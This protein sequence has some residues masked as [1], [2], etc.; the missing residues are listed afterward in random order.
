M[1]DDMF[2]LAEHGTTLRTEVIAGATTFLTMAYITVVNPSVMADAGIAPGA[3][4]IATCLGAGIGTALMAVL[5]NYPIALAPGMGINAYFA[6]GVVVGMGYPWQTALGA[7]FILGMIFLA[8]SVTRFRESVVNAIPRAL[9]LATAAG[10]GLFLAFIGLK[11]AGVVVSDPATFVTGGD[12]TEPTVLLA[13]GCFFA[14]VALEV[15]KVPGALLVAILGTTLVAVMLGYQPWTGVVSTPPSVAPTFL[16]LD[17]GAALDV[18]LITVIFAFFIVDLFDSAGTLIGTAHVGG[19]LDRYGKLPKLREAL[20]ADSAATVAGSCLGTSPVTAYIESVPG[21]RAGGRTGLTAL[22]VA[23]LFLFAVFFAPL[24]A[25]VPSYA[26]APALIYVGCVMAK[27]LTDI[28]WDDLTEYTPALIT[29][30]SMPLTFSI[31]HGLG[32]G[33]VSYAAIKVATG[34]AQKVPKAIYLIAMTFIVFF[35]VE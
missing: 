32:F 35:V 28:D 34:R 24:A 9:Q 33:F 14:I 8:L 1:F 20:F 15:R 10:I 2:R 11:N 3:A 5:T 6:Y 16:A 13:V 4:F 22:V 31:T 26:A 30:I 23:V 25:M 29:A 19:F 18:G 17:I 27:S 12:L 21:I 7:V